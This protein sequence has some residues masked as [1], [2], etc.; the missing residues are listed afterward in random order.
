MIHLAGQAPADTISCGT[1]DSTTATG[2]VTG[3]IGRADRSWLPDAT[4][5]LSWLEVQFDKG[6]GVRTV[7]RSLETRSGAEGV[8]VFCHLDETLE[9]LLSATFEGR[10]TAAVRVSLH[11]S[12]LATRNL[13]VPSPEGELVF[14]GRIV[15]ESDRGIA[16]ARVETESPRD[17]ASSGDDGSFSLPTRHSGTQLLRSRAVGY[18]EIETPVD[19]TS[20]DPLP[21]TIRLSRTP[22]QLTTMIVREQMSAI[23][24]KTGFASRVRNGT[25]HYITAAQIALRRA[26]CVL[27]Y[28]AW[29][30]GFVIQREPGGGCGGSISRRSRGIVTLRTDSRSSGFGGCVSVVVDDGVED[31]SAI[32]PSDIVGIET[33]TTGRVNVGSGKC[34]AV[35]I[36]TVR[37]QGPHH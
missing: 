20:V 10:S 7:K 31:I 12:A 35:I 5:R 2:V 9:A 28:I 13:F 27:D 34:A 1:S 22:Q 29:S 30:P 8:F 32:Q 11:D 3:W 19:I 14:R 37:Y 23:A 36:W 33:Y 4:V 24:E 25:G 15:D 26:P 6:R 18:D 16:G 17:S 21:V